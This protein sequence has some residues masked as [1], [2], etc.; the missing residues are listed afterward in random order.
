[1]FMRLMS[2]SEFLIIPKGTKFAGLGKLRLKYWE[3]FLTYSVEM[4]LVNV[5]MLLETN[6]PTEQT[7]MFNNKQEHLYECFQGWQS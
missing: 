7:F 4:C 5:T 1:M 6:L 3:R 2:K